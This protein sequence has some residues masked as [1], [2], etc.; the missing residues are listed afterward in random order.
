MANAARCLQHFF[1]TTRLFASAAAVPTMCCI[2]LA[3]WLGISNDTLG[4][5]APAQP[6]PL[7]PTKAQPKVKSKQAVKP[8]PK[9]NAK[10]KSSVPDKP[11]ARPYLAPAA[12]TIKVAQPTPTP[13]LSDSIPIV[14]QLDS[15][16]LALAKRDSIRRNKRSSVQT[17]VKYSAQD[18]M[19]FDV[20]TNQFFL[21]NKSK[22]DYGEMKLEANVID[23]NWK[24]SIVNARPL[25][26]S[27]GK[28]KGVPLFE[29]GPDKYQAQR[30]KFNFKTKKGIITGL[31]TQN[32]EGYIQGERVKRM[33]NEEMFVQNAHYTTCNLAHPHFYINAPQIK[34]IPNDKIITGPFNVVIADAPTPLGFLFGL[35]P[36]PERQSAGIIIPVYGESVDRGFFLRNGGFYFPIGDYAGVKLLGEIYTKGSY[37]L[38]VL[39]N[40]KVRYGFQ[41]N[42]NLRYN[43]RLT[44]QEGFEN[45][46]ED[47]WLDWSHIPLSR[48]SSQFSASVS[49]GSTNYNTLNSQLAENY[50]SS[51]FNSTVSYAK[52]L[53]GTPFNFNIAATQ[54]QTNA[55]DA[56]GRR[57]TTVTATLPSLVWNMNR[58]YPFK[59][60]GSLGNTWWQKINIG[61][62]ANAQNFLTNAAPQSLALSGTRLLNPTADTLIPFYGTNFGPL[63][64]RGRF[65]VQHTLPISTTLQ[66]FKY[67]NL[68]PS[69]T[70]TEVWS[71]RQIRYQYQ[72]RG[73]GQ[74]GVFADTLNQFGRA[75][76]LEGFGINTNTRIYGTFFVKRAGIEAIR[77]TLLP[78]I[79]ISFRPNYAD[80]GYGIYKR[81]QADSTGRE[82]IYNP[83]QLSP[84]GVVGAG[85]SANINFGLTNTFEAKV[86]KKGNADTL[87]GSKA[88]EK[89]TLFDNIGING[90]YNLLADSFN[91]SAISLTART[92]LFNKIDINM[93]GSLDPYSRTE[94]EGTGQ[95]RRNKELAIGRGQ[96]F[97]YLDFIN[98]AMSTSLTPEGLG[99]KP[100]T[101]KKGLDKMN[102]QQLAFV[103]ANPDLYVDFN[104]PWT[105]SV[106]YNLAYSRGINQEA[107]ITQT[108]N[109]S[110]DVNI[111]ENWKVG[112]SSGYDLKNRNFSYTNINIYRNLHC[113]E[114]KFNW[115]PFG[116]RQSYNID[117]NVKA[118]I[119]QDLKLSRRR[120]WYDR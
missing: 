116:F 104:I 20:A 34:M 59:R 100:N 67:F 37:G 65:G 66:A 77:H 73:P 118:S 21:Y 74:R 32:G 76:W 93:N 52:Q 26:D 9:T 109:F 111:T 108:M 91:L 50:L 33:P 56:R 42:L 117:I 1:L 60:E 58:I 30:I 47:Y 101:T 5:T 19:T 51:N 22:V 98:L 15:V 29:Q 28:L 63:F 78:S 64:N 17:A 94:V 70:Y 106:G 38:N 75:G 90:S 23:L 25:A 112:G 113:W 103:N 41:G 39:T 43:R 8:R 62:S 80:A 72:D 11:Q 71:T 107:S 68:S 102:D 46:G 35:F 92:R 13:R 6:T 69:L 53:T 81:V 95:L 84:Y 82:V 57:T 96:G 119:L 99:L 61:W 86:R 7:T 44:G 14:K 114:I 10:F 89:V 16:G 2:L 79:G 40:Y 55:A 12:D 48:G 31:V 18:S 54:Q 87:K 49:L 120:S 110:G 97:G 85:R 45:V 36:V 3:I 105:I 4:Q 24:T 115:I 83:F 88:F 27:T